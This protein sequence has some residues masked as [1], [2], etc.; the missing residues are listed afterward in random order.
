MDESGFRCAVMKTSPR[1]LTLIIFG[2]ACLL[3]I[4]S[5]HAARRATNPTDVGNGTKLV[6]SPM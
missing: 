1:K 6:V 2:F 5:A 4:T 3:S